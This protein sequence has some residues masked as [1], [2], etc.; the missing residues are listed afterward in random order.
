M[1]D[2]ME[3]GARLPEQSQHWLK[4]EEELVGIF[5]WAI[6]ITIIASLPDTGVFIP[7]HPPVFVGLKGVAACL[8]L[9]FGEK[10]RQRFT[11]R[12]T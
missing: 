12:N 6:G 7:V 2:L 8:W 1:G 9:I 10:C 5:L 4:R 3:K 11:K